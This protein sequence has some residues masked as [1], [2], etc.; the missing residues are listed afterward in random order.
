MHVTIINKSREEIFF[1]HTIMCEEIKIYFV[2]HVESKFFK[3]KT[4]KIKMKNSWKMSQ[5]N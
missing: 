2:F 3:Q 4:L 5:I 1:A